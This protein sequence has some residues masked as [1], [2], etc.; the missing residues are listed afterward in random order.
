[1]SVFIKTVMDHSTNDGCVDD[2]DECNVEIVYDNFQMKKSQDGRLHLSNKHLTNL[3]SDTLYHLALNTSTHNFEQMF[4]DIKFVCMGGTK[5]RMYEFAQLATK[6]LN[7]MESKLVDITESSHRFSMFK[8]GPILSISHGMGISSISILLH[9]ILKLL[10][11]AKCTNVT[12][13]RIGTSGGIGV[14]PG[15]VVIT[16]KVVDE[17][18]RPFHELHILG[19]IVRRPATFD[20]KLIEELGQ[21]ARLQNNP[22]Y[23]TIIGTTMCAMDFYESQSRIDGAICNHNLDD[24]MDRLTK[25]KKA[26]IIN[27]EMEALAFG[28]MCRYVNVDAAIICVT[29]VNRLDGDQI[30]L[31]KQEYHELQ[32][33]PQKLAIDFIKKRLAII[34]NNNNY[35][36]HHHHD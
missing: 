4:G 26:G 29:M 31:T 33:R 28:S 18:L 9:E 16:N 12:L 8:I 25:L 24:K 22:G 35:H 7:I 2:H 3:Q 5:K 1:M 30:Q 17:L 34:D 19:K 32:K 10:H 15:T 14:E 20:Q 36:H 11:Y 27:I 21:I 6:E 13:F 23:K